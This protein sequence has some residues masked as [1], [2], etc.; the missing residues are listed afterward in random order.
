M[1][2]GYIGWLYWRYRTKTAVAVGVR[3]KPRLHKDIFISC[4]GNK[5]VASL[6]VCRPSVAGY[7]GIG[8]QVDR[9]IS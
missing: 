5:I 1:D 2:G 7:K 8:L 6:A 4:I 3:I 9:D